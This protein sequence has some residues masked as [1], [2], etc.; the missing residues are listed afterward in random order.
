[1]SQRSS[2]RG[3]TPALAVVAAL[4][5]AMA[6]AGAAGA[7]VDSDQ[8]VEAGSVGR[9]GAAGARVSGGAV[10]SRTDESSPDPLS[11]LERWFLRGTD[12]AEGAAVV[13]A[14]D[15]SLEVVRAGDAIE[16][17]RVVEV[18][19]DV[20][21][22]SPESPGGQE[23]IR[24]L[25]LRSGDGPLRERV[26]ELRNRPELDAGPLGSPRPEPAAQVEGATRVV[27]SPAGGGAP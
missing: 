9:D 6:L 1:M 18:R 19:E 15:G 12:A 5:A 3:R 20:L 22:L 17:F 11:W 23:A 8:T 27:K 24:E 16:S 10:E 25:W 4:V 7:A 26:R 2:G 14:P 13:E 21:V